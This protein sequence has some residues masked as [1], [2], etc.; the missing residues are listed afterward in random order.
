MDYRTLGRTDIKVG[1]ICLGTMTWGKQN[2]EAEGHEQMDYA[3]GQGVNFFDTAEMYAVPTEPETYGKTEEIIGTWFAARKNRDKVVLATKVAGPGMAWIRGGK[4]VIDRRNILEAVEGSLKRLQTD[5]IDLYQL[6]WPNRSSPHFSRYWSY[7]PSVTNPAE[8]EENFIDVLETLGE[9]VK[10]G[11]IRHAGLSNESPWGVMTYLRLAE[12]RGLPRMVSIQNEYS[13][14]CRHFDPYLAET[15]QMENVGLLAWSPLAV[16]L[17]SG[18]YANGQRP[19]GSRWAILEGRGE[20]SWRD[21]PAAHEAVDAY[22]AVAKKHG[23]D[24][25]QMAIAFVL[26]RPFVTAAIIGATNMEQLRVNIGSA[27]LRLSD[28]ALKDIGD[29]RRR[30]PVPY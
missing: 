20:T 17:L 27:A 7:D 25:C 2:T 12:A 18:K 4:A 3:L 22:R 15:A 30:Y 16:G 5:Y 26:S 29:V 19:E 24:A 23:L 21:A 10:A 8:T 1:A 13:L 6:H 11:K 28:A 14:L 9:L